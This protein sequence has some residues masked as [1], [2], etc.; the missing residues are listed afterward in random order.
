MLWLP[1]I[2]L[3]SLSSF[4]SHFSLPALSWYRSNF[5]SLF[6]I[7]SCNDFLSILSPISLSFDFLKW[8]FHQ[9]FM[10]FSPFLSLSWSLFHPFNDPTTNAISLNHTQQSC[11]QELYPTSSRFPSSTS[12]ASILRVKPRRLSCKFTSILLSSF[13]SYSFFPSLLFFPP[14]RVHEV[15][16]KSIVRGRWDHLWWVKNTRLCL[17]AVTS[18]SK[19]IDTKQHSTSFDHYLHFHHWVHLSLT[20]HSSLSLLFS[21]ILSSLF[22][23]FSFTLFVLQISTRKKRGKW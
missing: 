22:I 4:L 2:F 13:L 14:F 3:P 20:H 21:F 15:K 23:R 12:P 9:L 1:F 7:P 11:S 16:G 19:I 17:V 10:S 6:Q 8:N 18:V 5:L